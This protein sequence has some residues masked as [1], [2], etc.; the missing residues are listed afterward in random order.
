M[1]GGDA[2]A[3][4][5]PA[6]A[7][8]AAAAPAGSSVAAAAA[9]A[10]ESPR[11]AAAEARAERRSRRQLRML[12]PMLLAALLQYSPSARERVADALDAALAGAGL[13]TADLPR[14]PP[15]ELAPA[16]HCS[17]CA[18]SA[19]SPA[20][21]PEELLACAAGA[22]RHA[23]GATRVAVVQHIPPSD[24]P[25]AASAAAS[26]ALYAAAHGYA[27]R[28]LAAPPSAAKRHPS[29]A[30]VALLRQYV[31]GSEEFDA[32]LWLEPHV[33][34]TKHDRSLEFML[35]ARLGDAHKDVVA[36]EAADPR[37]GGGGAGAGAVADTSALLVRRTPWTR[38]FLTK[39]WR[40][41]SRLRAAEAFAGGAQLDVTDTLALDA[42]WRADADGVQARGVLL[43]RRAL[44]AGGPLWA[45]EPGF[46]LLLDRGDESVAPAGVLARVTRAALR[47][48]CGATSRLDKAA[49]R[50]AVVRAHE[51]TISRGG[52]A[53]GD[54][55]AA[56][57]HAL[58]RMAASSGEW[59]AAASAL[60]AAAALWPRRGDVHSALGAALSAL[61][62][63]DDAVAAFR[64]AVEV[65]RTDADA[66]ARLAAALLAAQQP[67]AAAVASSAALTLK[68]GH[69]A[70]T[71]VRCWALRQVG[72]AAHA[73]EADALCA[74][75]AA[76]KKAHPD[77]SFGA[78]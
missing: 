39:W 28:L 42:M 68:P 75:A 72:D 52:D 47:A 45:H 19:A 41:S 10:P 63:H 7:A 36:F 58:G 64:V 71:A 74:Q 33:L 76:H 22:A 16:P 54:A 60:R 70:A 13:K 53:D 69:A 14:G 23:T 4:A 65:D 8:P 78:V 44:S 25:W 48:S 6:A 12:F 57:Q 26:N 1:L 46:A 67:R 56:A 40:A 2:A 61:R 51:V 31:D 43:R 73:A 30:K 62:Q 5:K 3:A 55:V 17:L 50:R 32:L 27:Y 29:W 49:L 24:A 38:A 34:L 11:A 77:S 37:S 66:H 15:A 21:R 9:N 59:G 35:S 20:L 18:A